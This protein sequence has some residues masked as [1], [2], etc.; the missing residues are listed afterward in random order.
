MSLS[1]QGEISGRPWL[2]LICQ[3][4]G[5][6]PEPQLAVLRAMNARSA[7]RARYAH[8]KIVQ[9]NRNF[10]NDP[11]RRLCAVLRL[12]QELVPRACAKRHNQY[13]TRTWCNSTVAGARGVP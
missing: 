12:L 13:R 10:F 1:V 9:N 2:T 8:K 11:L 4:L 6:C 7:V 3:S 5:K